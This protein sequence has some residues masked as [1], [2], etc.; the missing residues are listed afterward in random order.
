MLAICHEEYD[1]VDAEGILACLPK[2]AVISKSQAFGRLGMVSFCSS[3]HSSVHGC[4]FAIHICCA[5]TRWYAYMNMGFSMSSSGCISKLKLLMVLGTCWW[6]LWA[7]LTA[8][9]KWHRENAVQYSQATKYSVP[10]MLQSSLSFKRCN[11]YYFWLLWWSCHWTQTPIEDDYCSFPNLF[12][13]EFPQST[14]YG[15]NLKLLLKKK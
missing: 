2:F 5:Q 12:A 11:F 8:H 10:S 15:S 4:R 6:A 1:E 13:S 7:C 9:G 3:A 14:W